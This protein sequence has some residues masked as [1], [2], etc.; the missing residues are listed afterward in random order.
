MA[1]RNKTISTLLKLAISVAL[2]YFIFTKIDIGDF[3]STLK[4]SNPYYLIIALG[5]FMLSKVIAAFRLNLYFHK[6]D[7]SLNQKS[8][9]K[10]YLLGMFYNL[11]L[12]GGIG[13]DAYK[14]YIVRKQ[15]EVS[16]KK[17]I[18]VLVLDRLSGL[19]L[20]FL[21]ACTLLLVLQNEDL[22]SF[23]FLFAIAIPLSVVVFWLM[24]KYFF[25]YVLPVFW[26]S[27][28]YSALLQL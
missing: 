14:G 12:P 3:V 28:W 23:E 1:N 26:K 8:N 7:V 11:F 19:A 21:Y 25:A 20:L 18:S 16:T 17:V 9:L 24:N 10:L 5:L 2:I 6:I 4:K 13:G 27:L 15:F 22:N